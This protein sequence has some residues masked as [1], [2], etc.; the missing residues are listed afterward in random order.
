MFAVLAAILSVMLKS[1]DVWP[2]SM[3][4]SLSDETASAKLDRPRERSN[5]IGNI[6]Y[7]I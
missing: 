7:R 2:Q 5:S 4:G 6:D 1:L 3:D